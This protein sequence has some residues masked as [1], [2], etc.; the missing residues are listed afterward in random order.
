MV[1]ASLFLGT[2]YEAGTN[3]GEKKFPYVSGE[4]SDARIAKILVHASSKADPTSWVIVKNGLTDR[5][6]YYLKYRGDASKETWKLRRKPSYQH[7]SVYAIVEV[8]NHPS[9]EEAH[10]LL[11]LG[12]HRESM[13]E[14]DG[15]ESKLAEFVQKYHDGH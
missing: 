7:R 11:G 8:P 12:V 3:K 5:A 1:L 14:I 10:L 9:L 2:G 15:E 6:A 13:V 4:N